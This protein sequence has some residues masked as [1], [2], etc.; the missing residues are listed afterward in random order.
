[1][2]C[3]NC[4][5]LVGFA[6]DRCQPLLAVVHWEWR[7]TFRPTEVPRSN[8]RNFSGYGMGFNGLKSSKSYVH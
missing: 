5:Q 3:W 7:G 6:V 8:I 4:P 2:D 1:M